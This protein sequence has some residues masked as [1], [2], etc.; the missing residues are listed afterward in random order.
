MSTGDQIRAVVF[1]GPAPDAG[2]TA[3][4]DVALPE[5]GPGQLSIDVAFAGVN[6]KDVMARRGDA[7]YVT[8]WPYRPG[9]EVAGTV[10]GRGD[11]V[12][13]FRT[14]DRVVAYTGEGGLAEVAV[15]AAVLT[16]A[17]PDSLDLERAAA[18]PGALTTAV[19]LLGTVGRMRSGDS[20]LVHSAAGAVGQA[21]VRLARLQGSGNVYGTVGSESR[22]DAA[23]KSG[24]DV[25]WVRRPELVTQVRQQT[26]GRG[27]DLI[28]DPQ[29]TTMLDADLEIV[30]ATGRIVLFGNAGGDPF[31]PLP[32]TGRLFAGNVSI[33]GFSLA[34]L[35]KSAPAVLARA[36]QQ[37]IGHLAA[38]ELEPDIVP[39]AGLEAVADAQQAL[40]EG[41]GRGKQIVNVS[42]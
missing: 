6:F 26:G 10:R 18:A 40:A 2:R 5:P 23:Y 12:D 8:N 9:V 7:G 24:Y 27:V 39:V 36:L 15:A 4:R 37:T 30:A 13:G 35:S 16:V 33:G 29:G 1:D 32:P 21:I 14:G 20:I 41:R 42:G 22:I 34:S 38:G 19:L 11:G 25:V 3:V 31:G 17:V 28:L